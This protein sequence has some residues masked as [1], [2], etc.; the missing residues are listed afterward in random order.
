MTVH[1]LFDPDF[2]NVAS[3]WEKGI[4]QKN[5]Q[6]ARRRIWIEAKQQQ[7]SSFEELNVWLSWREM[8]HDDVGNARWGERDLNNLC[9]ASTPPAEAPTPTIGNGTAAPPVALSPSTEHP[10]DCLE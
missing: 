2:C 6:D 7:F 9:S 1:Y 10:G 4:V 5:V 8:N 3:G